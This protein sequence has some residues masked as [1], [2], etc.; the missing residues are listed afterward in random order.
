[1]THQR[2]VN[3]QKENLLGRESFLFYKIYIQ[4]NILNIMWL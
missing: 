4:I 2:C 3:A 1:M